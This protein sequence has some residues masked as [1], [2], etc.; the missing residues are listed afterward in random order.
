MRSIN[1]LMLLVLLLCIQS[2]GSNRTKMEP[3]GIPIVEN[4]GIEFLKTFYTDYIS[5]CS[6]TPQNTADLERLKR[7][8]LSEELMEE[9]KV[10]ELDY[11]P[12]LNAQ[13]CDIS[14][15]KTLQIEV[16]ESGNKDYQVSYNDGYGIKT[17][18]VSL[19]EK[20]DKLR[21][22]KIGDR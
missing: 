16:I 4:K 5:A 19:Q 12:F 3:T 17:I 1:V 13:D 8:F 6:A 21:I 22:N 20:N 18:I 11:D 14:W 15:V 9:L 7:E 2:C 10:A